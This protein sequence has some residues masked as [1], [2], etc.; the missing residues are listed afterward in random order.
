MGRFERV[1][2][3][4]AFAI[5]AGALFAAVI[6]SSAGAGACGASRPRPAR[7]P[8]RKIN[9]IVVIYEENHSFDNLYGTW[10]GVNGLANAER[11]AHDS[12][13]SERGAHPYSCRAL[14]D[15]IVLQHRPSD[16]RSRLPR[17]RRVQVVETVVF[18]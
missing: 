12:G 15:L 7:D 6:A 14:V 2:R 16:G 1:W 11:R 10:E 17:S 3:R 9:H 5:F 13:R 18:L 4:L 8:L